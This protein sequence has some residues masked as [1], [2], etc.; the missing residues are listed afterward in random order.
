MKNNKSGEFEISSQNLVHD[1][2]NS[3]KNEIQFLSNELKAKQKELEDRNRELSKLKQEFETLN[4]SYKKIYEKSPTGYFTFDENGFILQLNSTGSNQLGASKEFL[5]QKLFADFIIPEQRE[6]FKVHLDCVFTHHKRD[7]CEIKIKRKDKSSFYALL[8]SI[9]WNGN[10]NPTCHTSISDITQL[11][12]AEDAL[13]ETEARFQNMANTAPVLIWISNAD[14]LFTF[15]NNYWLQFTGR[16]LGQEL[17]MKWLEGIHPEDINHFL[18]VYKSSF[19][20]QKIFE[21]AFRLKNRNGVYRWILIKGIP[22][23]GTDG[24][25][26]GYIGSCTDI[27]DQKTIEEKIKKFNEELKSTNNSKDKFFSIIAHDLKNPLA[28]LLGFTEILSEEFDEL[29]DNEIREF[30][31]HSFHAAKNLNSLLENLLEWS[32]VQIGNTTFDPTSINVGLVFNEVIELFSQNA[33]NKKIKIFKRGETNINVYADKNMFKTIIRN[34]VS[35]GIKFTSVGGSVTLSTMEV[36]NSVRIIICDSGIGISP[37]N[38]DKLFRIDINHTTPGTNKERGTGL[39]LIL[40]NELIKKNG[41]TIQIESELGKGTLF[42][43]TLP[44]A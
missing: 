40:C 2:D 24:S 25:F 15:V 29:G 14:A 6:K 31:N 38:I 10:D 5:I 35:N 37:D 13:K 23:F 34:L 11:K 39:G 43:V 36:D 21:V 8:E 22:R 3:L 42:I 17:G 18:Q 20:T 1:D 26:A 41:G 19:D 33:N 44:K 30:I 12:V 7:T 28:G 32:R 9:P 27:T 4:V 16:T